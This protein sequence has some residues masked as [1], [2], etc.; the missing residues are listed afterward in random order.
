MRK[1]YQEAGIVHGNVSENTVVYNC[2][3]YYAKCW[4]TDFG[5]AVDTQQPDHLKLLANDVARVNA[6]LL[7]VVCGREDSKH[8]N[9]VLPDDVVMAYVTMKELSRKCGEYV[10]GP[11]FSR[12]GEGPIEIFQ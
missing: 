5:Y 12:Y 2:E 11:W 6:M 8:A 7:H 1:L 10:R 9:G 4:F 3:L